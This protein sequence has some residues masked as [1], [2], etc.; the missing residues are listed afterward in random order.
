M[1]THARNSLF[2]QVVDIAV[3]LGALLFLLA[4]SV[5]I[6]KPFLLPT[7]WGIILAVACYPVYEKLLQKL[8]GRKKLSA[9]VVCLAL[10]LTILIPCAMLGESLYSGIS[11]VRTS[12]EK[13][14]LQIP[15]PTEQVK[16]WPLI[17]NKTYE[18]WALSS[19]NIEEAIKPFAP[20]IK[21]AGATALSSLAGLGFAVI[22]FVFSIIIAGILL[23]SSENAVRAGNSIAAK[24]HPQSGGA[25]LHDAE[26]TVRNV[27]RG[28]LGVAVVQAFLAGLGFAVAGIP[29]AG[30]WGLLA[31]IT[32]IIQ[33]GVG[34]IMLGGVIYMFA[35]S[36]TLAA[37]LFLVWTLLVIPLDN[38]LKPI[39]LGQGAPVPMTVIFLGSLGGFLNSGIIGLFVG[40]VILSLAYKLTVLWAI[41]TESAAAP[42][43]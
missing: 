7:V 21:S 12:W 41:D 43:E 5:V 25:L 32:G 1:N 16:S 39:L 34:P 3:R 15:P 35:T 2:P 23:A 28:I 31:L 10:L 14:G 8:P 37:S 29:G 36:S 26:T 22:Q 9:A 27:A 30:L 24:L 6:L 4:W 19:K 11:L 20:Q 18:L 40:A 13:G 17:G 42:I 38:I 33:I